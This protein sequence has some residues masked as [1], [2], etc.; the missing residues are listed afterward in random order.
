M[1]R[2][3]IKMEKIGTQWSQVEGQQSGNLI[4]DALTPETLAHR[5]EV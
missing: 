3:R 5:K 2:K 1:V 4:V